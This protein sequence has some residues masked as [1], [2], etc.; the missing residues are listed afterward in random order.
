M[1]VDTVFIHVHLCT[2]FGACTQQV[3][4]VKVWAQV[5]HD[6]QLRHQCLLL[7]GA[8][9]CWGTNQKSTNQ[10]TNHAQNL[11]D[12]FEQTGSHK[13]PIDSEAYFF[14]LLKV[15]KLT[16]VWA[17]SLR[18]SLLAE[19]GWVHTQC[20]P[21]PSQRPLSPEYG[22]WQTFAQWI[23]CLISIRKV[24][25]LPPIWSVLW[26]KVSRGCFETQN[27]NKYNPSLQYFLQGHT[28]KKI[29]PEFSC[30]QRHVNHVD[31][32]D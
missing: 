22:L 6:L 16:H 4:N 24:S 21:P 1:C 29:T 23:I 17:S 3:D 26:V 27:L 11:L 14:A 18:P 13:A 19:N 25:H 5:S 31:C 10:L 7:T 15:C 9:C 20:L 12:K 8:S 30:K 28:L 2:W 32:P